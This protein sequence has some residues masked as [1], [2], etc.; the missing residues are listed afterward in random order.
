MK[1]RGSRLAEQEENNAIA[2]IKSCW[3]L[4]ATALARRRKISTASKGPTACFNQQ[5]EQ[6]STLLLPS[7]PSIYMYSTYLGAEREKSAAVAIM[8]H[9]LHDNMPRDWEGRSRQYMMLTVIFFFL[10]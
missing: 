9:M 4:A 3:C 6:S 8:I 7:F 2:G 5:E 1:R 10:T